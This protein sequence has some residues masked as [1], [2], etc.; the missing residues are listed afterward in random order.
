M[1]EQDYDDV[2][3]MGNKRYERE[4]MGMTSPAAAGAFMYYVTNN[5][6][7]MSFLA[8]RGC[9]KDLQE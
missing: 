4:N 6:D 7:H 8:L 1:V 9:V 5:W 3:H 2:R